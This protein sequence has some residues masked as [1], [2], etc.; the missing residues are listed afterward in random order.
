ME[1]CFDCGQSDALL[2]VRELFCYLSVL[3]MEPMLLEWKVVS[4]KSV[5]D[6]P[7]DGGSREHTQGLGAKCGHC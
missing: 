5:M 2:T 7:D 6:S 3:S 1:T 4:D